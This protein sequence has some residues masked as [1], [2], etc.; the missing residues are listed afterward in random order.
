[1]NQKDLLEI[2]TKADLLEFKK[3]L[4]DEIQELLSEKIDIKKAFYTPKEFSLFTGMAYST[5]VYRCKVGLLKARQEN[6]KSCW[7]IQISELER[8]KR[9]ANDN[10]I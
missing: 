4:L 1:M 6:P 10:G 3:A 2:P 9:E 5:V 8:Y 7:Q